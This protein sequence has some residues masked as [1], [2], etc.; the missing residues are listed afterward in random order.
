MTFPSR[1]NV[2][3]RHDLARAIWWARAWSDYGARH[4][5]GWWPPRVA[6]HHERA[7]ARLVLFAA[8]LL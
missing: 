3:Y 7:W 2:G 4:D 5:A 8:G 6:R 1:R